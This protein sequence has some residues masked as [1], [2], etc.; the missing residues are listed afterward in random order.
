MWQWYANCK[1]RIHCKSKPSKMKKV[2]KLMGVLTLTVFL[3]ISSP[4]IAQTGDNTAGTTT[5]MDDDDND[6]TGKWGLAGL[7]GLLGL[8]GLRKRDDDNRHRNTTTTNR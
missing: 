7:L 5:T 3:G 2:T 8:L 6:D 4:A 1:P